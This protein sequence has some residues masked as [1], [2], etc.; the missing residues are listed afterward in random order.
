MKKLLE[1]RMGQEPVPNN[2]AEYLTEMQQ[3]ALKRIENFGWQLKFI[4]RPLFQTP[5]VVVENA[6]GR[7]IGVLEESGEI[8]LKS[9]QLV[10]R[11]S[12]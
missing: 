5:M 3:M 6:I 1:K 12:A 7:N 2:Y 10:L 9:D 4:R 11:E 8:N